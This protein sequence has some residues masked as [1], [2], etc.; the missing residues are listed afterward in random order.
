MPSVW[1]TTR[2]QVNPQSPVFDELMAL[3]RKTLGIKPMLREALQPF[4]SRL[5][6]A[7]IY[8]CVARQ[9]DTAQSDI[10]LM[11]VGK[12]LRLADVLELLIPLETQLGRKIN[13]TAIRPGNSRAALQ[14]RI[15]SSTAYSRN[16][17]CR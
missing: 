11:L 3:I 12:Q 16:P 15:P 9:S 4:A 1:G 8:G 6:A 17:P 5:Q 14:S 7:W 2:F 13:P 10:D